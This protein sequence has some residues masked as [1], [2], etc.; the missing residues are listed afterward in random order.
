MGTYQSK[1]NNSK[2]KTGFKKPSKTAKKKK[3]C[4]DCGSTDCCC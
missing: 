1:L 2:G 3:K 4:S